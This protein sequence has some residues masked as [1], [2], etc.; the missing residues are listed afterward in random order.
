MTIPIG[1]VPGLAFPPDKLAR[2]D[3]RRGRLPS[4]YRESVDVAGSAG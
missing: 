1:P 3:R 4:C 2:Y